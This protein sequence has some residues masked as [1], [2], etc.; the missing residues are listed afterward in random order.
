[1]FPLKTSAHVAKEALFPNKKHI[2]Q[3]ALF[4]EE[5]ARERGDVN[6]GIKHFFLSS[7]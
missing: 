5:R 3:K 1:M 4:K 2:F 6:P 7:V